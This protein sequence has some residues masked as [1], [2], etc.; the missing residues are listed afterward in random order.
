M[1]VAAMRFFP[2]FLS[3]ALPIG[4]LAGCGQ[5]APQPAALRE[6]AP[7][8]T[9]TTARVTAT[10][11]VTPPKE[12]RFAEFGVIPLCSELLSLPDDA[13]PLGE[14]CKWGDTATGCRFA[15]ARDA[16][17]VRYLVLGK[18]VSMKETALTAGT[19]GPYGLARGDQESAV[20]EKVRRA[21]GL[22]LTPTGDE[23]ETAL[24][25]ADQQCPGN[26]FRLVVTLDADGRADEVILTTLPDV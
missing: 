23:G 17:S 16:G 7:D 15:T 2:A 3:I 12:R 21:T 6:G 20:V 26:S 11:T 25:S 24:Q 13:A 4:L 14:D 18:V 9:P 22:A 10:K 8:V 19:P 5:G 1:M